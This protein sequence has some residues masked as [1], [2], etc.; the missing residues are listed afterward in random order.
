MLKGKGVQS[1]IRAISAYHKDEDRIEF[2]EI[3]YKGTRRMRTGRG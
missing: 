3:Y 1:G 2:I